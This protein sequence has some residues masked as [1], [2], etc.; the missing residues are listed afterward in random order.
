MSDLDVLRQFR[1]LRG[2]IVSHCL[3]DEDVGQSLEVVA[4]LLVLLV[5]L[6]LLR[7]KI[8]LTFN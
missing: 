7:K 4:E 5:S 3:L 2:Q 6:L 8:Y 1:V